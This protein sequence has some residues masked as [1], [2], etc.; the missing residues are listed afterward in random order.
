MSAQAVAAVFRHS[1]CG[2]TTRLVL[3]A[4]ANYYGDRGA[5]PSIDSLARDCAMSRRA[6]QDCVR[7]A[8]EA[9][10]LRVDYNAGEHGTNRYW[11]LLEGVQ[12]LHGGADSRRESAPEPK[13][14]RVRGSSKSSPSGSTNGSAPTFEEAWKA[15]P[16]EGRRAKP[17]A[18]ERWK[19]AVKK[20]SPEVILAGIV[21]YRDDPNRDPSHTKWMQG[22]LAD[23][24]WND[25]P[26][27]SRN[28]Q[29]ESA[30]DRAAREAMADA[31]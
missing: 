31:Y 7:R 26:L 19:A 4:I 17:K 23:E 6:V 8:E 14:V 24:R 18:R 3:L 28:G 5:W 25:P 9:G 1:K 22:W 27:P 11:L 29:R 16:P 30:F 2:G 13:E 21:A 12:I 20:A 10:E 15:Y